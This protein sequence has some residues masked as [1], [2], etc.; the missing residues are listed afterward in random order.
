MNP[1]LSIRKK[2]ILRRFKNSP[3]FG[4]YFKEVNLKQRVKETTFVVFDTETS[5][6]NPKEAILLSVGA[7]KVSNLSI[8]LSSEFHRFIKPDGEV[9][10]SSIEVHGIRPTELSRKGEEAEQ[11]LRDFL[12]YISGSVL[13]GFYTRFDVRVVSRYTLKHFGIP[14]LNYHL[15]VFELYRRRYSREASLDEVA[16]E[17]NIPSTARHSALDDSY[18][19]ALAFLKLVYRD[20]DSELTNLPLN[21]L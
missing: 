8:D 4:R 18:I 5:G 20:G 12:E 10:A 21:I 1:L 7:L 15:D 6:L 17:L 11:V 13:V 19:T 2:L 16:R 9:K 14:L 3:A